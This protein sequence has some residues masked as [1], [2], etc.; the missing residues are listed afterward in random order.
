MVGFP[1]ESDAEFEESYQFCRDTGFAAIHVFMY[2]PRPNTPA[3]TMDGQIDAHTKKQRSLSM[4]ALARE[5]SVTYRKQF[6]GQVHDVLWE[7][8]TEPETGLFN[9]LTDNYIRVFAHS[10][11]PLHNSLLPARLISPMRQGIRGELL[12]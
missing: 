6:L 9:G 4:L 11:R 1:G 3:A 2:S 8:E 7:S 5:S 10:A 12:Q